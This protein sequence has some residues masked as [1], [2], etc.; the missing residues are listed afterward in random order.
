MKVLTTIGTIML[1][2]GFLASALGA[3]PLADV[4]ANDTVTE[5]TPF[6]TEAV[7]Q[8]AAQIGTMYTSIIDDLMTFADNPDLA[9]ADSRRLAMTSYADDL[10]GRFQLFAQ[11]LQTDLGAMT[12]APLAPAGLTATGEV[13][14]VALDWNDSVDPSFS[15]YNVYRST[16]SGGP[17]SLTAAGV[18]DSAFVDAGVVAGTPYF[19]VVT[20]VNDGT[21]ESLASSEAWAIPQN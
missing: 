12:E 14:Q 3:F 17:Y 9:L 19:Y 5:E 11:D 13:G 4:S 7:E 20:A 21:V 18:P 15:F 1:V 10:A 6:S 8:T 2:L 16:T